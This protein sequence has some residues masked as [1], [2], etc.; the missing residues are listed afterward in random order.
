VPSQWQPGEKCRLA[1]REV[2]ERLRHLGLDLR[3]VQAAEVPAPF[4]EAHVGFAEQLGQPRDVFVGR[5]EIVGVGGVPD[6]LITSGILCD[7]SEIV[8]RDELARVLDGSEA[9]PISESRPPYL[10]SSRSDRI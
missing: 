10:Q 8:L 7:E 5:E 9:V 3:L 1:V 6:L 4:V 2:G